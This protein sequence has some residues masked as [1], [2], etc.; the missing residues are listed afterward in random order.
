[1]SYPRTNSNLITTNE[2]D[3]LVEHIDDYQA[4][5]GKTIETPNR[6]PRKSFVNDKKSGGALCYYSY[7]DHPKYGRARKRRTF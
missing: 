3:Y 7:R 4:A 1:M 2:F 6:S 5:I